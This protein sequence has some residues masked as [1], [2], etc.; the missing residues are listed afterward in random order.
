MRGLDRV[1]LED[2]HVLVRGGVEHDVGLVPLEDR[3]QPRTVADVGEHRL[4]VGEVVDHRLVQQALVAVEE[5]QPAG[6]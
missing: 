1:P 6:R 5:Q 4:G 3:A 2:R